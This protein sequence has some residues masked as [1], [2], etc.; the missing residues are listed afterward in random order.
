L[1]GTCTELRHPYGVRATEAA[2]LTQRRCARDTDEKGR[3]THSE[4]TCGLITTRVN[5]LYIRIITTIVTSI[6]AGRLDFIEEQVSF[7][8]IDGALITQGYRVI[9]V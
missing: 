2:S 5:A 9:P 4:I 7:C 1:Q 8:G 6:T 3:A